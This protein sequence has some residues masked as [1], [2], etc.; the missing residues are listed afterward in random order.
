MIAWIINPTQKNSAK[1]N[2]NWPITRL[3]ESHLILHLFFFQKNRG[4]V[5][6]IV[7]QTPV[8]RFVLSYY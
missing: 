4:A 6:F 1:E 3:F 8:L 2:N 7:T 5:Y